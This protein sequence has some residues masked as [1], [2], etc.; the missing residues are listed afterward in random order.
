M[1]PNGAP[2]PGPPKASHEPQT[3]AIPSRPR[4]RDVLF[5]F[6]PTGPLWP[7]ALR[8]ALAF[9]VPAFAAL[10][11]GAGRSAIFCTIG[12]LAV[13]YGQRYPFVA[14]ARVI[15]T[16]GGCLTLCA[17]LGAFAARWPAM[18]FVLLLAVV[19]AT[20]SFA[21]EALRLGP[22]GPL[23]FALATVLGGAVA[24]TGQPPVAALGWGL[25]GVAGALAAGLSGIVAR[26][27][28][29]Q[30]DAVTQAEETVAVFVENRDPASR[31][32]AAQ[33][34]RHGWDSVHDAR[35]GRQSE[36]AR[37]MRA[38]HTRL[39]FAVRDT[40]SIPRL[41]DAETAVDS[42]PFP[43]RKPGPWYRLRRSLSAHSHASLSAQRVLIAGLLGGGLSIALG[44]IRP[45]W[46]VLT[47]TMVL[48]LG[49]DRW[50]GLLRATQRITGTALGLG[51]FLALA[52][53]HLHAAALIG[54]LMALQFLTELFIPRNFGVASVFITPLALLAMTAAATSVDTWAMAQARIVETVIGAAAA[55]GTLLL[56]R[57]T[58]YAQLS[59]RI[60]RRALTATALLLDHL[61]QERP[62]HRE[63]QRLRRNLQY[64]LSGHNLT[65]RHAALESPR[66][67]S[68][69]WQ[70]VNEVETL[71]YE[72]LALCALHEAG[73]P[74]TSTE[75]AELRDQ[76]TRL[77][78]G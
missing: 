55:V 70:R 20:F 13:L 51:L 12:S 5:R 11:A 78:S 27:A 74:Y 32:L 72:V 30:E 23:F 14:R 45:E 40:D 10:A 1:N 69:V 6:N 26:P 37:R 33:A 60:E 75:L 38:A 22:P 29:P 7:S 67:A 16:A 17:L 77:S 48:G 62:S 25:A 66:W 61:G 52:T 58:A 49:P 56:Y 46:A 68:T 59:R 15:L 44:L 24:H 47:S 19:G 31:H 4:A 76:L 53:Q 36:L 42:A 50:G 54:A 39:S 8:G 64:E 73:H 28:K 21:N 3:A 43:L 35:L 41:A 63:E 2:Q 71:G 57:R 18:L 65:A 34:L 9:G